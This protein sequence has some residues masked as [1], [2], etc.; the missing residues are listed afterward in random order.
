MSPPISH[1]RR[2]HLCRRAVIQAHCDHRGAQQEEL[3]DREA[4]Q[5]QLQP[6]DVDLE[7]VG[8]GRQGEASLGIYTPQVGTPGG[9]GGFSCW[10]ALWRAGWDW[11]LLSRCSTPPAW[12][13]W[14]LSEYLPNVGG[15]ENLVGL[16]WNCRWPCV[17][18]A[19]PT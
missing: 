13:P 5:G 16:W 3:Q 18:S 19:S 10:C 14:V 7:R 8:G 17:V 6:L 2:P 4:E 11:A 15:L 12:H 1:R 9:S